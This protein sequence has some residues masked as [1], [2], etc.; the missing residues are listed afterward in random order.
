MKVLLIYTNMVKFPKDISLGLGYISAKLKQS[1]HEVG[2][3]D[4]TFG[5]SEKDI[6]TK[7]RLF[8]PALIGISSNSTNF[9]HALHI[10]HLIRSVTSTPVI[11]GG[12]HPTI[13]PEGS[14]AHSCFDMICV[15]EGEHTIAKLADTLQ[16]DQDLGGVKNIWF[17]EDHHIIKNQRDQ[18]VVDLDT[19]P[20]PDRDIYDYERYLKEHKGTASFISSRGCPFKCTYCQV[21]QLNERNKGLGP[22]MRYHSTDRILNEIQTVI[23]KYDVRAVEF[24]DDTFTINKQRLLEF[25]VRYQSQI[26]LPFF[27]NA[28]FN[29]LTEELCNLM[30][31]AG[32]VRISFGLESGDPRIRKEILN[33][34]MTDEQIIENCRWVHQAGIKIYTYNMIGI[35]GETI[36]SVKKT[37]RLNRKIKVDY[38]SALIYN[39]FKGTKLYYM[40]VQQGLLNPKEEAHSFYHGS[41]IKHPEFSPFRL[42]WLRN[43]FGFRVFI[44]YRPFWAL[45][46]LV[47]RSLSYFSKYTLIR[48]WLMQRIWPLLR[49]S[50]VKDKL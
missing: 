49:C 16:H 46:D 27:V 9:K 21:P 38:L 2:L 37:I 28:R 15:G 30:G 8:D 41:N 45:V 42:L 6:V 26:G 40:A 47:D 31:K 4:T 33:R 35:P 36:E 19:L 50:N 14:I 22:I 29:T 1:G 24:Y 7:L 10:G 20:M 18:L 17:K 3:I 11:L 48:S 25:C 43:T 12:I 44:S 23:D 13:D 32:C 39:G 34:Q 5:T